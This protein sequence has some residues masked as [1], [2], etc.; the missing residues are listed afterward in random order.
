MG[1]GIT[2]LA[3]GIFTEFPIYESKNYPGGICSSY[4]IDK[5]YPQKRKKESF[6]KEDYRFE[7]GGGHWIFGAE[8]KIASF[9]SKYA[10]MKK[11]KRISSV[12]L[13][14]YGLIPYPIQ[15]NLRFFSSGHRKRIITE[16]KNKRKLKK[17]TMADWLEASF[18]PT[19]YDLFFSP[20]N[21][22]YTG[23]LFKSIAAQDL[24][25]TPYDLKEVLK[26]TLGKAADSG[27]NI[28][29][30]YPERGLDFMIKN[31][32]SE[33]LIN[34][35]KHVVRIDT[36]SKKIIFSDK[37]K[38][39]Y[40]SIISTLPL[41]QMLRLAGINNKEKEDPHTS[42][43]IL[44]I[45]A[46]R[47]VNCPKDHWLYVAKKN[48]PFHRIG[49]YSNVDESF[50]PDSVRGK[51][52]HVSIYVEKAFAGGNRPGE[53]A[54]FK[55]EADVINSLRDL[56]FI[57]KIEIVDQNWIDVAYTWSWPDSDWKKKSLQA[58]SGKNIIQIG[59]YGRWKFQ[60]IAD[61]IN[62]AFSLR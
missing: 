44:N 13:D 24:Y 41:N 54:L 42:V 16:L 2:G 58:L 32:A 10:P 3:A 11:Y 60:G 38:I 45:A 5:N 56:G 39:S 4:Y 1:A 18:G 15:N 26:G 51:N 62:E 28:N 7:L 6:G 43:L 34:Y 46:Q 48:F 19:L 17:N 30:L 36:G 50:L 29:F 61:S 14:D 27:Y 52:T 49:F 12:L 31:M 25:K 21:E 59:R 23:G 37:T 9:I 55:Y 35:N 33:C 53:D 47:G 8:N 20:F 57:G 40:N 22:L